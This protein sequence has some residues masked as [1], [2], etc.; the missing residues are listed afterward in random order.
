MYTRILP[1]PQTPILT[2][3]SET[4]K[5]AERNQEHNYL[6]DKIKLIPGSLTIR[7]IRDAGDTLMDIL[8]FSVTTCFIAGLELN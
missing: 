5:K 1:L 4:I 3:N 2:L 7:I 6:T 8:F